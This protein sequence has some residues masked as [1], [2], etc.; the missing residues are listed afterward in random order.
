MTF[1]TSPPDSRR[2]PQPRSPKVPSMRMDLA[3]QLLTSGSPPRHRLPES[4]MPSCTRCLQK[5]RQAV[6]PVNSIGNKLGYLKPVT[7]RDPEN[8]QLR[9]RRY[10]VPQSPDPFTASLA[11]LKVSII[12]RNFETSPPPT[13][14][15]TVFPAGEKQT[16]VGY[17]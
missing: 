3:C 8:T 7:T 6:H 16:N 1:I 10:C 15:L 12:S 14:L 17:A 2:S 4:G 11:S 5:P 9:K 13:R